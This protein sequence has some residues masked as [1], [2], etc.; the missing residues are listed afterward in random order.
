MIIRTQENLDILWLD[1]KNKSM[2]DL[3]TTVVTPTQPQHVV[4]ID[5]RKKWSRRWS[6][7]F[8]LESSDKENGENWRWK[9]ADTFWE[10]QV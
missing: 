8:I 7:F 10:E 2:K 6:R 3:K 4:C 5:I 1:L 9:F